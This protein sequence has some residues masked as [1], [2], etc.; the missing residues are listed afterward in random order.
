MNSKRQCKNLNIENNITSDET[1]KKIYLTQI[2]N[3]NKNLKYN[4]NLFI[5]NKC[6]YCKKTYSTPYNL[7]VHIKQYCKNRKFIIEEI[8]NINLKLKSLDF[9]I[10]QQILQQNSQSNQL[11]QLKK[12]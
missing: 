3:L 9:K 5:D 2:E 4:Y 7:K 6:E 11:N 8:T 12:H 10:E 1:I